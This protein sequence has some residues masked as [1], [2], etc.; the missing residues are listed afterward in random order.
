MGEASQLVGG[1]ETTSVINRLT[2]RLMRN[3]SVFFKLIYHHG[4]KLRK[5]TGW[6][7]QASH[8]TQPAKDRESNVLKYTKVLAED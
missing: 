6:K 1:S 8:G 3:S 2:N 5:V 4:E 7:R